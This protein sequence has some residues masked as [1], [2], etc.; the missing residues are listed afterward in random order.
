M[1]FTETERLWLRNVK[2][3]DAEII[4]DYRN[5]PLCA[6][7]Q[8]GQVKT[9]SEIISLTEKRKNDTLAH[10][11]SAFISVALKPSTK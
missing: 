10:D 1:I 8:R 5:H 4:Y 3:K 2:A 6:R 11:T 7:Y 9:L